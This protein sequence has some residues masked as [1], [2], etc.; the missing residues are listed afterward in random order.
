MRQLCNLKVSGYESPE[1]SKKVDTVGDVVNIVDI[2]KEIC[3]KTNRLKLKQYKKKS[4]DNL[5][6]PL[7]SEF[8]HMDSE[9]I[10]AT[11][12]LKRLFHEVVKG[13]SK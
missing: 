13:C 9:V 3:F 5:G 8:I 7:D 6:I 11:C 4:M 2:V 1:G 12:D 10:R